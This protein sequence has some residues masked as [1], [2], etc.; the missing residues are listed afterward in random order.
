MASLIAGSCPL[1]D[2]LKLGFKYDNLVMEEAAQVL[3]I[4][5]F[6]PML[7]QRQEDG[8]SRLKR[9]IL[10]GDHHQLP[11]VVQN[12]AFQKYSRLDQSLF[13]RFVRLGTPYVELNAQGRARPSLAKLYNWR[14]RAL[15]DLP[16][17]ITLPHFK[18]ANAGFAFDY[19]FI[20]VPDFNGVGETEPAPYFYQN[21][22]EA[23][24]L[25]SVYQYMRLLGYPAH[26]I[27]VLT[28]YNGQKALL[29]DVFERR[30]AAN[31]L[32]GRP[33]KV[34]TVDKFQG[35]Q[36]DFVL[37]SLVKTKNVGHLR[38]VRRLVV[39]MSRAR[40]G[41]YIFGRA[42]LFSNCYELRP[43]F[44]QLLGR[45]TQLCLLPDETFGNVSRDASAVVP[46]CMVVND[47]VQMAHFVVHMAQQRDSSLAMLPAQ[48]EVEG[49]AMEDGA[50]V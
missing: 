12:M 22:A 15:G 20:D 49:G 9:V 27:S 11:P 41:L 17:V 29:R 5:T 48:E 33:H 10:I 36:N 19:Q 25:V 14:Y 44:Q 47:L 34:T 37:M 1:Q 24:Y 35:Q 30:C 28:T 31:P 7:L 4:E 45:A 18:A 50:D 43:T 32:F 21:L 6:I 8:V 42:E 23:E 16:N 40:L 39:A 38:D 46:Q 3:E 2:F 26:R 13:S